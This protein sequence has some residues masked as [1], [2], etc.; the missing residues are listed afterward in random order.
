MLIIIKKIQ[1]PCKV[2]LP[3]FSLATLR[4]Q[5]LFHI[6]IP[7]AAFEYCIFGP[8]VIFEIADFL[9]SALD[10][11]FAHIL[12]ETGKTLVQPFEPLQAELYPNI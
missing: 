1:W 10:L 9:R 3:L 8:A 4:S 2:K 5:M 7:T 11:T 6:Y 12:K